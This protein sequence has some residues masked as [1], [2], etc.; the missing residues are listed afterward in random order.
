[1]GKNHNKIFLEITMQIHA[2]PCKSMQKRKRIGLF[3]AFF[4]L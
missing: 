2:I 1:M 3:S 4:L